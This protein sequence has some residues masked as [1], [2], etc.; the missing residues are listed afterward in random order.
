[1]NDG[2]ETVLREGLPGEALTVALRRDGEALG[3][4]VVSAGESDGVRV[5]DELT[6]LDARCTGAQGVALTFNG[7]LAVRTGEGDDG[8]GADPEA[9]AAARAFVASLAGGG[10]VRAMLLRVVGDGPCVEAVWTALFAGLAA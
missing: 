5:G 10:D 4:V 8:R 6:L 9:L 3:L 1:M 7:Q 2:A